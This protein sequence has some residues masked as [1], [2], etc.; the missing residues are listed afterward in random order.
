MKEIEDRLRAAESVRTVEAISTTMINMMR[1]DPSLTFASFEQRFRAMESDT[2]L[3]AKPAKLLQPPL[4][5][6]STDRKTTAETV[7]WVC[8][9]GLSEAKETLI[10]FDMTMKENL[11]ALETCGVIMLRPMR[12]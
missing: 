11:S 8:L 10:E 5:A 4:R 6:M 1:D 7:L 2:Y 3:I 12:L 9:H